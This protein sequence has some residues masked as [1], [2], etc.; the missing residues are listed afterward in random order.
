MPFHKTFHNELAYKSVSFL[1]C[2]GSEED[3]FSEGIHTF[4]KSAAR[5]KQERKKHHGTL[6]AKHVGIEDRIVGCVTFEKKYWY[7]IS[8]N[9]SCR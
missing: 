2:S 5:R 6:E 1:F 8:I 7:E 9:D 4:L 3:D